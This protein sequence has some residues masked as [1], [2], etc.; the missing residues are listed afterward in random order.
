VG[1]QVPVAT[2][3]VSFREAGRTEARTTARPGLAGWLGRRGVRVRACVRARCL[4]LAWKGG[5]RRTD[6]GWV[7]SEGERG[8]RPSR[9]EGGGSEEGADEGGRA[10]GGRTLSLARCRQGLLRERD[11]ATS[12][13]SKLINYPIHLFLAPAAAARP[14]CAPLCPAAASSRPAVLPPPPPPSRSPSRM[15]SASRSL[16]PGL[17]RTLR[18]NAAAAA[19][20]P[21]PV[22]RAAGRRA[23]TTTTTSSGP[24]GRPAAA[25]AA[26]AAAATAGSSSSSATHHLPA[27]R[28]G[29]IPSTSNPTEF[30]A[31]AEARRRGAVQGRGHPRRLPTAPSPTELPNPHVRPSSPLFAPPE[32]PPARHLLS[33]AHRL[34]RRAGRKGPGSGPTLERNP[35]PLCTSWEPPP[36]FSPFPLPWWSSPGQV[37][38]PSALLTPSLSL[39]TPPPLLPSRSP[40]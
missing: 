12:T 39:T 17:A 16:L 26:A 3:G 1:R 27:E 14:D 29:H 34:A 5:S 40:T 6:H 24:S 19:C 22:T 28:G 35:Y 23:S 8:K 33:T 20:R 2:G 4:W 7:E 31:I 21:C 38:R 32:S 9:G 36:P 15:S 25:A 13:R 10:V 11:K 37:A 30:E 18:P